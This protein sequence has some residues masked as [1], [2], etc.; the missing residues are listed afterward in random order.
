MTGDKLQFG[1]LSGSRHGDGFYVFAR[2][3]NA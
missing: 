3:I 2:R 1:A